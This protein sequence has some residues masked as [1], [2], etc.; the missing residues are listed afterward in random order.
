[1]MYANMCRLLTE[2]S[3]AS[4]TGANLVH[5][6]IARPTFLKQYTLEYKVESR[7]DIQK[8]KTTADVDI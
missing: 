8:T 4:A 5:F 7:T 6:L 3:D 1:M 2:T